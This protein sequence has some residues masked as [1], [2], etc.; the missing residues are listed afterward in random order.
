VTRAEILTALQQKF[1]VSLRLDIAASERPPE[2]TPLRAKQQREQQERQAA[3]VAIREDAMVLKLQQ[4]FAAEL[5]E[6]SV[7]KT[8]TSGKSRG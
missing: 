3:I 8:D 2:R 5:D 7:V 4:A 6:T 1:G